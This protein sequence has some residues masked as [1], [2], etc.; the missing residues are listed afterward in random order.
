MPFTSFNQVPA[1][2][3]DWLNV[4]AAGANNLGQGDST[5]ALNAALASA[6]PGQPV[7]F[8][9][10][11]YNTS[12]PLVI[13][14]GVSVLG[15]SRSL[16]V[17]IGNYGSGG[18][19]VLGAIIKPTAGFAGASVIQLAGPTASQG[20]QQQITRLAMDGTNV[21]APNTVHGI[22]ATGFCAAV[23]LTEVLV[24]GGVITP[25]GNGLGGDGLHVVPTTGTPDF[26]DIFRCK[27]SGMNGNGALLTAL[28][29]SYVTNC[30]ATGNTG[31]GWSITNGNNSRYV[32]CKAEGNLTSGWVLTGNPGFAG[33]V[34]WTGC[35][36]GQNTTSGFA[37]SG[38]GTGTY[39]MNGCVAIDTTPSTYAGTMNLKTNAAWNTS[40]VAPTF[41]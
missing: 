15:P 35:T 8:P 7:Y 31:N 38:T 32:D 24:Y 3:G 4:L 30:E 41:S 34:Y 19:P 5:A 2:P 28:A 13:P 11:V 22:A 27:F 21:T 10:G 23:T 39:Y 6:A 36:S 9:R 25:G 16:G 1:A 33:R 20:G 12:A 18:L 29:D 14:Q 17:P 40:T 26:W 37:I